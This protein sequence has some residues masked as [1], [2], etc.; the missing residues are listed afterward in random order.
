MKKG[1][2]TKMSVDTTAAS[3]TPLLDTAGFSEHGRLSH[4]ICS[5]TSTRENNTVVDGIFLHGCSV[6][7]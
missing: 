3:L 5:S 1:S 7:P 2:R 6:A 4:W